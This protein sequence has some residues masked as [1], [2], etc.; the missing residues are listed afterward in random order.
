MKAVDHMRMPSENK[1]MDTSDYEDDE[2]GQY[3]EVGSEDYASD[4][5]EVIPPPLQQA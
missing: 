1:I 4:E 5:G 2:D 3:E